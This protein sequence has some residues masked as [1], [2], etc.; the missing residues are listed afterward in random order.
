MDLRYTPE[1]DEF[2]QEVRQFLGANWPLTGEQ[3]K[4]PESECIML[5]RDLATEHG[6]LYRSIP[7]QYGGSEQPTDILLSGDARRPTFPVYSVDRGS[8]RAAF[9]LSGRP[10]AESRRTRRP[11]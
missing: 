11:P 4:L 9:G 2:R 8:N 10:L 5:F 3:A 7:R 6:Y 1:Y